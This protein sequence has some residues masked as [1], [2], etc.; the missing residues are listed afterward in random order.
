MPLTKK[1]GSRR[2]EILQCLARMLETEVGARIT[3]ARL[4]QDVGVSEAAL[5]RHFPSK[6]KMY[7]GLLDFVEE[8]IFTRISSILAEH[9]HPKERCHLIMQLIL[10]FS[11]KNP[12]ICRLLMGDALTGEHTRLRER[13]IQFFD[14]IEVQIKQILR[15]GQLEHKE[16][17]HIDA[18]IFANFMLAVI[19]GRV[20]QFVRSN[21]KRSPLENWTL[22]WQ[23]IDIQFH[24]L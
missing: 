17:S 8:S 16:M 18:T 23:Y 22:Q 6:A 12:G 24:K 9:K 19:E 14:R 15:E 13:M 3:T 10:A 2:Q 5:Y 7:E 20:Q 4:A 1:R 11:D 21:F